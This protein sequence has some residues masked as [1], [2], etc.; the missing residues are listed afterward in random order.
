[1]ELPRVRDLGRN[2]NRYNLFIRIP[3]YLRIYI[4][5]I[6]VNGLNGRGANKKK[7][8]TVENVRK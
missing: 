4:Y 8:N 6:F 2:E 7:T 3:I 5:I 1:M